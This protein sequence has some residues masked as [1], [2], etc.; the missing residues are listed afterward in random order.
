MYS[1]PVGDYAQLTFH[2]VSGESESYNL[3]TLAQVAEGETRSLA[4]ILQE[5]LPAFFNKDWLMLQLPEESVCIHLT[6]V[7]RIEIKPSLAIAGLIG[8][9]ERL[10]S[11]SRSR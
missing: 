10:T 5:G 4:E 2:Y 11:L 6:Q 8:T 1:S 3:Y 9:G 7:S